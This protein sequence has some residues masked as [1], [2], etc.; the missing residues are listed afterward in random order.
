MHTFLCLSQWESSPSRHGRARGE[1][2]GL[3]PWVERVCILSVTVGPLGVSCSLLQ[4]SPAHSGS[5][6]LLQRCYL[7]CK[8]PPVSLHAWP[9]SEQVAGRGTRGRGLICPIAGIHTHT[10]RT[11]NRRNTLE[12]KAA[13]P[14]TEFKLKLCESSVCW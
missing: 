5:R 1:Y 4:E 2:G 10:R 13:T 8:V 9:L 12:R 6:D 14:L 7:Q 11:G 3:S